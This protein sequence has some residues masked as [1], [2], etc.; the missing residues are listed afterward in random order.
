MQ[1][2]YYLPEYDFREHH[3]ININ[4][5]PERVYQ[6]IKRL[7]IR[8]VFLIKLLFR[9]RDFYARKVYGRKLELTLQD[10]MQES[11]FILLDEITNQEVVIGLTG[12]FWRPDGG[13]IVVPANRFK[14]FDQRG[15]AK[16]AWNFFIQGGAKGDTILSTE[17]RIKTYGTKARV[18]FGMYWLVI[19]PFSGLIRTLILKEIDR[20]AGLEMAADSRT[21]ER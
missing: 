7:D 21:K 19:G 14:D 2:D 5:S 16:V 10:L 15:F 3:Q 9:L 12:R 13:G 8:R 18:S 17:T 20:Q 4:A 1:I 11:G 6:I